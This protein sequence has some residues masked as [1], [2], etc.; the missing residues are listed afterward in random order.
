[1]K[2]VKTHKKSV[3]SNSYNLTIITKDM[4]RGRRVSERELST[5]RDSSQKSVVLV[6]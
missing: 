5:N 2:L 4:T 3:K 1:M 6:P